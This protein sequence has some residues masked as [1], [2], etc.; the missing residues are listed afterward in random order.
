M[1]IPASLHF[2]TLS[3][4]SFW[5]TFLPPNSNQTPPPELSKSSSSMKVSSQVWQPLLSLLPL[6]SGSY[7]R[8]LVS[9][10]AQH[11]DKQCLGPGKDGSAPRSS[12]KGN[13]GDFRIGERRQL[14]ARQG[15]LRHLASKVSQVVG[16]WACVC[17]FSASDCPSDL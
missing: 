16:L 17:P 13:Q 2:L 10:T 7:S 5:T 4:P 6:F 12:Q 3:G 9:H 8:S 11:V 1:G 14:H 15:C